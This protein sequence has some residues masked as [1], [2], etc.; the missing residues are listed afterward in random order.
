M[1]RASLL[2]STELETSFE[3]H[4]EST[5]ERQVR[6]HCVVG[7]DVRSRVEAVIGCGLL[8]VQTHVVVFCL[9][10]ILNPQRRLTQLNVA[11]ENQSFWNHRANK[12]NWKRRNSQCMNNTSRDIEECV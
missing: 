11:L 12:T 6:V 3:T 7:N 5:S 1:Q 4:A 8:V 10:K 2:Y 9:S